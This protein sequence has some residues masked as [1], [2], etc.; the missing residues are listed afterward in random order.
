MEI[1]NQYWNV[2]EI[3]D[4]CFGNNIFLNTDKRRRYSLLKCSVLMYVYIKPVQFSE[5]YLKDTSP[6]IRYNYVHRFQTC[7]CIIHK[8]NRN[9]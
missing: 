7:G 4:F 2:S 6:K 9:N 8:E 1:S 5:K 3:L